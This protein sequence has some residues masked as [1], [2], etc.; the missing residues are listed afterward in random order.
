MLPKNSP[1]RKI[2]LKSNADGKY[3]IHPL[4]IIGERSRGWLVDT[5]Q[6]KRSVF[7]FG[8]SRHEIFASRTDLKEINEQTQQGKTLFLGNQ[9]VTTDPTRSFLD[10]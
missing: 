4:N 1:E 7:N 10:W 8:E 9:V 6:P 2:S 5:E 3:Y